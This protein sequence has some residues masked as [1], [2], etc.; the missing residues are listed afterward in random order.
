MKVTQ[1]F[2]LPEAKK[3]I[4]PRRLLTGGNRLNSVSLP[5]PSTT[6]SPHENPYRR[7]HTEEAGADADAREVPL[8]E[9]DA[10]EGLALLGDNKAILDVL[11]TEFQDN[12]DV[13]A[14]LQTLKDNNAKVMRAIA[15][16][17]AQAGGATFNAEMFRQS[18]M[19]S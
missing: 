19:A 1:K 2:L 17:R 6:M 5:F 10:D 13:T 4:H 7:A 3:S 16:L 14:R 9:S 8:Y 15:N 12:P 11:L 18:M